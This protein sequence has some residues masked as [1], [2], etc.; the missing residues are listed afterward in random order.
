LIVGCGYV[1]LEAG[2]QW[3]ARGAHVEGVRRS[4]ADAED[5]KAAGIVLRV[6]DV[7][8]R[9]D[10]L[11]WPGEWDVVVNAV[12]S[13]RGGAEVYRKVYGEGTEHLLGW[14][15]GGRV[16]RYVHLSSTS[17]YG[18]V[19]GSWVDE[20]SATAP[21]SETSRLLV[22]TEQRL[23]EAYG[24]SGLPASVLRVAGIYGPGRGHQLQQLL[25]SEARIQG[26]GTRW[27]NMVHRDDVAS[28]IR[29]VSESGSPGRIYN[30]VDDEPVAQGDFVLWLA[31]EYGLPLPPVAT[32]EENAARKRGLTHKRVRNT[33]L[34]SETAW[35]PAYPTFREGYRRGAD[36][37]LAPTGQTV[38]ARGETPG[39]ASPNTLSAP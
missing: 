5:L 7:T 34:R 16:G 17:V 39:T 24:S 6:G 35:Q 37:P 3:A 18:Q 32:E 11:G 10:V 27:V 14:M 21:A 23:I 26:D 28:A 8:R 15:A 22:A 25:R 29:I 36:T 9:E 2:R 1:G 4:A 33:R 38:R 31:R 19:D 12:S 30:V 20:S 13:S